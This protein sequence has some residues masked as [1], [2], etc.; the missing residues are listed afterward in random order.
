MSHACSALEPYQG[1]LLSGGCA[2]ELH[3]LTALQ[4]IHLALPILGNL[5]W[6]TWLHWLHHL[7]HAG[8]TSGR[9][10]S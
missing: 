7:C 5:L 9:T 4:C 10:M 2:A 6:L 8:P 3:S 1:S